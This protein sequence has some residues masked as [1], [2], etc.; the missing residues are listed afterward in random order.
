M[1]TCAT[2]LNAKLILTALAVHGIK[3]AP[4]PYLHIKCQCNPVAS[5]A[6]AVDGCS[7]ASTSSYIKKTINAQKAVKTAPHHAGCQNTGAQGITANVLPV[8]AISLL[9]IT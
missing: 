5:A 8:R 9:C 1:L 7:S 4:R 2:G 6:I 3:R